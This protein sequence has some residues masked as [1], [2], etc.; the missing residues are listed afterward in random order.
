M[1]SL[2]LKVYITKPQWEDLFY[3]WEDPF[4]LL[5][6]AERIKNVKILKREKNKL[7][8]RWEVDIEGASLSWYEEDTLDREKGLIN[9]KMQSGDFGDYFGYWKITPTRRGKLKLE[10][11]ANYDWGIPV[12]EP[13]VRKVLER[14]TRIMLRSFLQVIKK[15]LE[16]NG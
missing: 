3:I 14:K 11:K 1:Y 5:K 2:S 12:L 8:T 4:S 7:Y 10:L 13:Y 16:E 9:F 15:A 6:K